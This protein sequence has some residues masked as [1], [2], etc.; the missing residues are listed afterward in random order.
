VRFGLKVIIFIVVWSLIIADRLL[1]Y[2]V[3]D[4]IV[5]LMSPAPA[6]VL[7]ADAEARANMT[8]EIMEAANA[9][10]VDACE[11]TLLAFWESSLD[12]HAR[13]NIGEEGILQLH[14]AAS[15]T[16]EHDRTTRSGQLLCGARWL[17]LCYQK[18]GDTHGALTAYASGECKP[19]TDA[20]RRK[21]NY[22]VAWIERDC[23]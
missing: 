6:R 10:N 15:S 4:I 21:I 5:R 12:E 17:S 22:R 2:D 1:E 14:G 16:C 20:T 23:R 18:C 9:Y 7:Y 3:D 8:A 11:L 13:G 19:R